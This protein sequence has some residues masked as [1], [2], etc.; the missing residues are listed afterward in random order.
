[1]K[2]RARPPFACKADGCSFVGG[3]AELRIHQFAAH[4][5]AVRAA[6]RIWDEIPHAPKRGWVRKA[7]EA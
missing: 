5:N 2:G 4:R 3:R 6:G 1:M 7:A